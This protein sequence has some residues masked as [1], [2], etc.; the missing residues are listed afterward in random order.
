MCPDHALD[1]LADRERLA[2]IALAVPGSKP[3]ETALRIFGLL[4][5][6]KEQGET[7]SVGEGRP[8][9]AVVIA[10]CRLKAAMENDDQGRGAWQLRWHIGEHAQMTRVGSEA[11]STNR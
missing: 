7:I 9:C 8:A 3:V 1:H 6:R 10:R 5:L 11:W 2:L 4:L